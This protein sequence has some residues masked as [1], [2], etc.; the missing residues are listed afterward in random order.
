[1]SDSETIGSRIDRLM[2]EKGLTREQ[3]GKEIGTNANTI[4]HYING[5][6]EPKI[7]SIRA[8]AR[9]LGVT[10]S[11]LI[12]G[13]DRGRT[14]VRFLGIEDPRKIEFPYVSIKARAGF[15][16]STDGIQIHKITET[17]AISPQDA[18]DYP[19]AIVMEIEGDSMEPR[20]KSG[21]KVLIN[22]IDK[23]NWGNQYNDVYVVDYDQ[24][25]TIKR[26]KNNDLLN[27]KLTLHPS[28]IE[29]AGPVTV[30][31]DEIRAIWRVIKI[32]DTKRI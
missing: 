8:I 11:F 4:G 19:D 30:S 21:D 10:T 16:Q 5:K 14:N 2:K 32:V 13:E 31:I 12:D 18:I 29:E 28:N 17:F 7:D 24:V 9:K 26:I 20:L 25:I 6:T 22:L 15:A 27:G 23:A 1:M 3:L